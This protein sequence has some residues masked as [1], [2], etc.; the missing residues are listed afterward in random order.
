MTGRDR[1]PRYFAF[2]SASVLAERGW[3]YQSENG[4]G[5]TRERPELK[6]LRNTAGPPS[7]MLQTELGA[8]PA[9]TVL[10]FTWREPEEKIPSP[11]PLL[12]RPVPPASS[13]FGRARLQTSIS[14]C[15][16]LPRLACSPHG[17]GPA[18]AAGEQRTGSS[19][20]PAPPP[21][22]THRRKMGRRGSCQ[23]GWKGLRGPRGSPPAS[24]CS[25]GWRFCLP[26]P[27]RQSSAEAARSPP[28]PTGLVLSH[29]SGGL[30][31][32]AAPSTIQAWALLCFP[33]ACRCHGHG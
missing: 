30:S 15:S 19:S 24:C 17:A 14:A 6:P 3:R 23:A 28:C 32:H 9:P 12:A 11:V 27:G 5:C 2:S 21:P 20:L 29:R 31:H 25:V 22:L 7:S 1:E 4:K 18:A 26:P 13:R 8:G 33:A 10:L 16:A